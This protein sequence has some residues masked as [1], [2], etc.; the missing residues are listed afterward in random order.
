MIKR[1]LNC[2][3]IIL[4]YIYINTKSIIIEHYIGFVF[5]SSKVEISGEWFTKG[6]NLN[7]SHGVSCLFTS[8]ESCRSSA[9]TYARRSTR[10]SASLS[11]DN[12]IGCQMAVCLEVLLECM[13]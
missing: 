11:V 10:R 13:S 12:A 4:I 2:G 3:Y 7:K 9:D 5:Q 6:S 8:S 1:M